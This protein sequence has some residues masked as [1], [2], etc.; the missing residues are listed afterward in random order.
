VALPPCPARP[1]GPPVFPASG[2]AG[3][4]TAS[5]N[6]QTFLSYP[7]P[8][9]TPV[10]GADLPIAA[11]DPPADPCPRR[12]RHAVTR[13]P[14]VHPQPEVGLCPSCLYDSAAGTF[15]TELEVGQNVD[16]ENAS[17]HLVCNGTQH[18]YGVPVPLGGSGVAALEDL[19]GGCESATFSSVFYE[20]SVLQGSITEPVLIGTVQ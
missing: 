13:R 8:G 7:F 10:C 12:R 9:N 4:V 14:G 18:N 16:V 6:V 20:G 17:L 1:P 19:P 11:Q 3:N 5:S 15:Y 2:L